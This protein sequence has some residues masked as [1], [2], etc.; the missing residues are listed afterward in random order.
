LGNTSHY[1]DAGKDPLFPFG[2]GLSYTTFQYSDLKLS[3]DEIGKDDSLIA[4]CVITNTGTVE[5]SEIAQLYIRDW[6]G[7]ITRPVKELKAFD[8]ISLKPGESRTVLFR[9]TANDLKFWN[10]NDQQLL[11]PGD[12][13]LWIGTNSA[14]GLETNFRLK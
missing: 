7:S 14:E 9:L 8:K 4:S 6:V 13:T 10:N 2:Y 3:S 11:E 1:L 12:F 5:G